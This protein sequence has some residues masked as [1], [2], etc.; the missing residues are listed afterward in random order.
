MRLTLV[1][2]RP[3]EVRLPRRVVAGLIDGYR[4]VVEVR[5]TGRR[6]RYRLTSLGYVGQFEIDGSVFELR[7]KVPLAGLLTL[8]DAPPDGRFADAGHALPLDAVLDRLAVWLADELR[9]VADVGVQHGYRE[10][11]DAGPY[12]RGRLDVAEQLRHPHPTP[13]LYFVAD[14]WTADTPLN[15]YPAALARHLL[16][17]GPTRES[18]SAL[19]QSLAGWPDVAAASPAAVIEEAPPEYAG[20]MRACDLVAAALGFDRRRPPGLHFLLDMDRVFE[21]YVTRRLVEADPHVE[22]QARLTLDGDPPIELRPD[23]LRRTGDRTHWV[24]DVKWKRPGPT[25]PAGDVHQ[26]LSYGR[27][28]AATSMHLVYPGREAGATVYHPDG[29]TLT[30]HRLAVAGDARRLRAAHREW[31]TRLTESALS[32]G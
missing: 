28:T 10:R 18:A 24:L 12:L 11:A 27:L 14:E 16:A 4:G 26:I 17:A 3:R 25:T 21:Q 22:S 32:A 1:E 23:V 31:A 15:Q 8:L 2:R 9:A 6:D 7:P 5:P 20:L 29:G 30:A 13:E 19:T